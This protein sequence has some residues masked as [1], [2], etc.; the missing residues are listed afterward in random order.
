MREKGEVLAGRYEITGVLGRGGEGN[1]YAAY[2]RVAAR[3]AA[4]KEVL[5]SGTGDVTLQEAG[6][7]RTLRHRG[8]PKL[9]Q[10]FRER[11][12]CYVVTEYVEGQSLKERLTSGPVPEEEAVRIISQLCLILRYLHGQGV[13]FLDLKPSNILLDNEGNVHLIDF[14]VARALPKDAKRTQGGGV[15]L[16]RGYAAPEQYVGNG[17]ISERTDLYALGVTF[18]Y[19]LTGKNPNQ[20]PFVFE[21]VR[22]LNPKITIEV[23]GIVERLLQPQPKDRYASADELLAALRGIGRGGK[24]KRSEQRNRWV[25]LGAGAAAVCLILLLAVRG[26]SAV[27]RGLSFS[28]PAGSYADY[29]LLTIDYDPNRGKVYYTVDGTEPDR[30]SALYR[31]GIVLSH[32]Y[33]RVRAK[34][35]GFDGSEKE[36]AAEY[37][38]TAPV[39]VVAASLT[40]RAVWDIYYTLGKPWSE[41]LYNYEL[42]QIRSLPAEDRKEGDEWLESYMPFYQPSE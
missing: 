28:L 20:P 41:P 21:R 10:T 24:Q 11:G 2:D 6:L 7:L 35:L 15:G 19:L 34:L 30:S 5:F 33:T 36:T 37:T 12:A 39:E 32:P 13:C 8:L 3:K 1:V 17:A 31:D 23:E 38:V 4:V 16:T 25:F 26:S 29:Q 14:G 22:K 42:A 27:Q 9:Y 18:H 40:E